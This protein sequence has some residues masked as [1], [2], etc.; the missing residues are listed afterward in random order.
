MKSKFEV[1]SSIKKENNRK[2]K[3]RQETKK[4]VKLIKQNIYA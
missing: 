1:F 4:H 2:G 3:Q